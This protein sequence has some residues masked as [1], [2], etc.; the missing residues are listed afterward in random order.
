MQWCWLPKP[1]IHAHDTHAQTWHCHLSVVADLC[2]CM[3][4]SV[5][6]CVC[7]DSLCVT[8]TWLYFRH[9]QAPARR[10]RM[11]SLEW[12]KPNNNSDIRAW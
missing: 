6:L 12:P 11:C 9:L 7:P 3:H 8:E 1:A 2:A 10:I 5:H 4:L